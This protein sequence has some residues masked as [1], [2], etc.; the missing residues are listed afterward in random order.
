MLYEIEDNGCLVSSSLAELM[1]SAWIGERGKNKEYYDFNYF[2]IKST[3]TLIRTEIL[4]FWENKQVFAENFQIF[5][6]F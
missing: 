5:A 4:I 2:K 1:W 6:F 3:F